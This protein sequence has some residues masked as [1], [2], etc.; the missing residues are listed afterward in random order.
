MA[1]AKKQKLSE[2]YIVNQCLYKWETMYRVL[3]KMNEA[4]VREAIELEKANQNR[5]SFLERFVRRLVVLYRQK[6]RAEVF[7]K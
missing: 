3:P 4:Q 1:K 5:A 6:T 7:G 2:T